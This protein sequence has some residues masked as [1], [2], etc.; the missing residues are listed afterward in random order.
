MEWSFASKQ[1]I[2]VK[3]RE[4]VFWMIDI[5]ARQAEMPQYQNKG[6]ESFRCG[7]AAHITPENKKPDFAIRPVYRGN[8]NKWK[9]TLD[10]KF[11][12]IP[13][14]FITSQDIPGITTGPIRYPPQAH[15]I[16]T[17]TGESRMMFSEEVSGVSAGQPDVPSDQPDTQ[18]RPAEEDTVLSAF[19]LNELQSTQVDLADGIP[20]D[21]LDEEDKKD[22]DTFAM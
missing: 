16:P 15:P 3:D 21:V 10:G 8:F 20:K 7:W 5:Q 14:Y 6:K 12:Q 13:M 18:E 22:D 19:D 9:K 1:A 2:A 11:W 17:N 4:K